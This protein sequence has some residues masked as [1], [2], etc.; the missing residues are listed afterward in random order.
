MRQWVAAWTVGVMVVGALVVS[1]E[2]GPETPARV[3]VRVHVADHVHLSPGD[4]ADATSRVGAAYRAAGFDIAWT[5]EALPPKAALRSRPAVIE[6]RLLILSRT[7][8]ENAIRTLQLAPG[9]MGFA[10]SGSTEPHSR[11]AYV[12]HD[13]VVETAQHTHPP[14][15]RGLGHVIAHEIGHLLLGA[16]SHGDHGLMQAGWNV[17]DGRLETFTASEIQTIR[18]RFMV[19]SGR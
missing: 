4:W 15:A 19:A 13:R 11:I 2:P 17:R 6:V 10:L 14:V 3:S 5:S 7:M 16:N 1:A 18:R 12:F 8:A 9:V